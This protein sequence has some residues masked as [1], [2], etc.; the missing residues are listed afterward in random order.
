MASGNHI[1]LTGNVTRDPELRFTP[2]GAAVAK[3]GLAVNRRWQNKSTQEWE[4][5]V[6]FFDIVAWTDLGEHVAESVSKGDRVVVDGR[7]DQRS[8]ETDAGEKRYAYEVVADEIAFGLRFA[9]GSVQRVEKGSNGSK[10]KS[11][12][13]DEYAYAGSE[14]PF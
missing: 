4:E 3:F 2:N 11:S 9:T 6:S 5:E 14:E 8:W 7:I 12:K 13:K 1:T 10:A